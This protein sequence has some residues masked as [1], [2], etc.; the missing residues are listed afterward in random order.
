ML[1]IIASPAGRGNFVAHLDG[2]ELCNAT[3]SPFL[4]AAR[5]L[6]SEGMDQ[7][8]KIIMRHAGSDIDC[9]TST[10]GEA[11]K[12]CVLEERGPRFARNRAMTDDEKD[13]LETC[14]NVPLHALND[15]RGTLGSP[16]AEK[17]LGDAKTATRRAQRSRVAA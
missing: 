14:V 10:I 5:Q 3:R 2:R 12:L 17:S 1:T 4:T 8:T 7:D 13:V 6:L 11:A 15:D 16:D 9:L